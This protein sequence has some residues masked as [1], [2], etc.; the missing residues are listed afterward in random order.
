M[1]GYEEAL[2]TVNIIYNKNKYILQTKDPIHS[3]EPQDVQLTAVSSLGARKAM[4]DFA[5]YDMQSPRSRPGPSLYRG[6][7][8]LPLLQNPIP[9]IPEPHTYDSLSTL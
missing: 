5:S 6:Q 2:D 7:S 8:L 4:I 3:T 9:R 1:F